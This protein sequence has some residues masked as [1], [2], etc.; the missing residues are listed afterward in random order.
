MKTKEEQKH[1]NK[2]VTE[3]DVTEEDFLVNFENGTKGFM[4]PLPFIELISRIGITLLEVEDLRKKNKKWERLITLYEQKCQAS[5][6]LGIKKDSR[7][8]LEY[9]KMEFFKEELDIFHDKW[10]LKN[11]K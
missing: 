7:A 10:L 6:L 3:K 9:Y 2:T 11:K 1:K 4:T 5:L 8:I